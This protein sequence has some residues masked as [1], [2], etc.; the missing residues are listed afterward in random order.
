MKGGLN[1]EVPKVARP[2]H[3]IGDLTNRE[4]IAWLS[5][6][7]ILWNYNVSENAHFIMQDEK[8]L[9]ALLYIYI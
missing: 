4:I 8:T 6:S 5:H 2:S 9:R 1:S 3:F 7:W